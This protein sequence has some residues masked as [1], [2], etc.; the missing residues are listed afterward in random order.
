[1]ATPM[2]VQLSM[3][4]THVYIGKPGRR[5]SRCGRRLSNPVSMAAHKGP[6]CR[7]KTKRVKAHAD[8]AA[9]TMLGLSGS[10]E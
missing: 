4:D 8:D 2:T 9:L 10:G 3:F 5:C 7:A 6:V 1:M